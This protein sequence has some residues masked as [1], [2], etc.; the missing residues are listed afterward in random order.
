MNLV[1]YKQ[2]LLELEKQLSIRTARGRQQARDQ[3]TDSVGDTG[4]ASVTDESESEDFTEAELDAAVLQQVR[5][6]LQR[7]DAG[8]FGR[9]VVDGGPIAPK[10]LEAVPWTPYCLKH[11]K[12]L[13]AASRLRTP[14][15]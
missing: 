1:D 7:I 5:D 12:L 2:R 14:T 4:D 15:F 6:A 8:S 9:C 3:V 13:E 11:Q 10:R